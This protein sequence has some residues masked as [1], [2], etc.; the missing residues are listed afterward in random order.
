MPLFQETLP[1]G[2]DFDG[3]ASSGLLVFSAVSAELSDQNDTV[4]AM[5]HSIAVTATA[6][7]LAVTRVRLAPD[8]A[9]AQ[10]GGT[11]YVGLAFNDNDTEGVSLAGCNILVPR[12]FDLYVFTTEADPGEKSLVVDWR[13]ITLS[14][15]TA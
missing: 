10:P 9:A 1:A 3:T 15:V 6:G 13:T 8:T 5:V 4:R 14:P 11:G 7:T 2:S 12:G